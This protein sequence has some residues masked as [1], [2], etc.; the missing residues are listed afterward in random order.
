[1]NARLYTDSFTGSYTQTLQAGTTKFIFTP[2][3]AGTQS[4]QA[5]SAALPGAT[6]NY[7]TP[8]PATVWWGR[9]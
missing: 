6:S 1:M 2:V 4:F 9:P 5:Q 3:V 8:T 7:Y